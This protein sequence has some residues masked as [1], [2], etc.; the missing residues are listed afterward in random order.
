M[1]RKR[2]SKS[3]IFII[4]GLF[5]I[6][7]LVIV[8]LKSKPNV[9]EERFEDNGRAEQP[10]K[11]NIPLHEM[12]F[13]VYDYYFP[14]IM[15]LPGSSTEPK[16][17]LILPCDVDYYASK[18][19][20]KPILTLKKGTEVYYT[21]SDGWTPPGYGF[22]CWPD[23]DKEWRYGFVFLTE[24]FEELPENAEMYYVKLKQLEKVAGEV[25]KR[26]KPL[27]NHLYGSKRKTV[28]EFT[29]HVDGVLWM[30]GAYLSN[31]LRER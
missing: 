11:L 12:D 1:K 4:F 6:L 24:G 3:I 25:Y 13:E 31:S 22:K 2:M 15:A 27:Y 19:D 5:I 21:D 14:K 9:Y 10:Y 26:N 16:V 18:E 28:K 20:K 8:V 17:T 7:V 23:Y 29:Q 30:N